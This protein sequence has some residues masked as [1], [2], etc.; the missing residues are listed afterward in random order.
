MKADVTQSA[1]DLFFGLWLTTNL[2]RQFTHLF[3]AFLITTFLSYVENVN[4]S[5]NGE[6]CASY[7]FAWIVLL[8]YRLNNLEASIW[9]ERGAGFTP[10]IVTILEMVSL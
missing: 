8:I 4:I 7:F 5:S 2:V 3:S 10:V 1:N 6:A 9:I